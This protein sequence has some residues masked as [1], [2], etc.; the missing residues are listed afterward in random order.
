MKSIERSRFKRQAAAAAIGCAAL[1]LIAFPATAESGGTAEPT[2]AAQSTI[3]VTGTAEKAVDPD[4]AK[5]IYAVSTQTETAAD[6]QQQN[7]EAVKKT[8]ELLQGLGIDE[9]SIATEFS[10][11]PIYDWNSGDNRITG[12]QADTTITVSDVAVDDLG[13]IISGS[14]E[15]GVNSIQGISYYSSSF[16]EVYSECLTEAMKMARS[17]AETIAAAD[18]RELSTLA[19]VSENWFDDSQRY[20]NKT[21]GG[22]YEE[23]AAAADMATPSMTVSPGQISVS[24]Q[25]S[26]SWNLQ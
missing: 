10:M 19:F 13:T 15:S 1:V 6:S 11:N 14:V 26:A 17:K 20:V 24:A 3:T 21:V 12:Y 25:L 22:A 7:D 16:D 2:N 5:I 18:G 9:K 8:L 23:S 4:Y